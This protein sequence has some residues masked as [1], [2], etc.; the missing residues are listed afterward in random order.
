MF[1][2]LRPAHF[3]PFRR[4][5]KNTN[6]EIPHV[7][8]Q[9]CY[10]FVRITYFNVGSCYTHKKMIKKNKFSG[11][12]KFVLLYFLT[13]KDIISLKIRLKYHFVSLHSF[14]L[15]VLMLA[16]FCSERYFIMFC[17]ITNKQKVIYPSTSV[18]FSQNRDC[19]CGF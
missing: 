1:F 9:N 10:N 12:F 15:T 13:Y 5:E 14:S 8:N 6:E 7:N 11:A 2:Q 17:P 3:K 16:D 4:A 19:S 18:I